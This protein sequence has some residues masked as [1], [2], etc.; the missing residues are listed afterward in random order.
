MDQLESQ[1]PRNARSPQWV[2]ELADAVAAVESEISTETVKEDRLTSD[3]VLAIA[4]I[5]VHACAD[6]QSQL[7]AIYASQRLWLPFDGVV[8]EEDVRNEGIRGS[9]AG[10][11]MRSGRVGVASNRPPRASSVSQRRWR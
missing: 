8:A 10:L 9:V 7:N 11:A 3:L 1:H 2:A 6:E 5:E 4:E